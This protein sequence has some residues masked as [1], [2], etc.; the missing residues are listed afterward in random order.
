[1]Q[2]QQHLE[3]AARAAELEED[4]AHTPELLTAP[5]L[6]YMLRKLQAAGYAP[7]QG[8]AKE[9]ED[10]RS[11]EEA[12]DCLLIGD[13]PLKSWTQLLPKQLAACANTLYGWRE[14]VELLRGTLLMT[15]AQQLISGDDLA[16]SDDY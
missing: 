7:A 3:A 9:Y 5:Q 15:T 10:A 16:S 12:A 4:I 6:D 1:Y 11:W 8:A 13:Q 2:V 14:E